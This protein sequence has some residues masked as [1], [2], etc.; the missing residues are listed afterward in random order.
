MNCNVI[1]KIHKIVPVERTTSPK[2]NNVL[3]A[4]DMSLA[5]IKKTKEWGKEEE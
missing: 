3:V 2:T 1:R 5:T 4:K